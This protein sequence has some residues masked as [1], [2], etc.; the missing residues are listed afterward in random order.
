MNNPTAERLI[1]ICNDDLGRIIQFKEING[2]MH[3]MMA[4]HTRYA[5][6]KCC[7]TIEQC[8]KGIISDFFSSNSS[9]EAIRYIEKN[10]RESSIN[11][12]YDNMRKSLKQFNEEWDNLFHHKVDEFDKIV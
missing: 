3:R 12:T 7:G 9:S 1:T 2:S 10:F 8:F 11:P 4:F 6:I 5:I